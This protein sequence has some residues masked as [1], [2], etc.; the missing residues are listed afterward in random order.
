MSKFQITRTV[1]QEMHDQGYTLPRMA[2]EL[3]ERAGTPITPNV[4]SRAYK[5][6][7]LNARN[8]RREANYEFVN[9]VRENVEEMQVRNRDQ[10][11]QEN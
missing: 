9:D 4:V 11:N 3:T 5:A 2:K 10:V 1:I 8:K 7:G 6:F